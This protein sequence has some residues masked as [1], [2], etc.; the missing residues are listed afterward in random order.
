[1][2]D[3]LGQDRGRERVNFQICKE[4]VKKRGRRS[5]EIQGCFQGVARP[6]KEREEGEFQI[7]QGEKKR[8]RREKEEVA[9][10]FQGRSSLFSAFLCIFLGV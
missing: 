7:L 5:K 10:H 2:G 3:L 4:R 1:M 9:N 6:T 8:E